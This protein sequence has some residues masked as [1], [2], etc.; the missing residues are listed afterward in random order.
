MR[1]SYVPSR[2]GIWLELTSERSSACLSEASS[3]RLG[4]S[5]MRRALRSSAMSRVAG[6]PFPGN[7][8]VIE[9]VRCRPAGQARVD[10][11]SIEP[12][13][14]V[15]PSGERRCVFTGR[16]A[17]AHP[18]GEVSLRVLPVKRK[19]RH[20][21][22]RPLGDIRERLAFCP[23]RPPVGTPGARPS[24]LPSATSSSTTPNAPSSE[25]GANQGNRPG[26]GGDSGGSG[27][28]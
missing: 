8:V 5:L 25:Q 26:G 15:R 19:H 9:F 2:H 12:T 28:K 24:D 13:Y 4:E 11:R 23:S 6:S 22:A 18:S 17:G 27:G 3:K 7:E 10:Q 14:G 21:L 20:C 1:P 16:D